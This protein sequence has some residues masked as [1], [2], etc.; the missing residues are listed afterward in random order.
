MCRVIHVY[1][2]GLVGNVLQIGARKT[3]IMTEKHFF[4]DKTGFKKKK[5]R[6]PFLQKEQE[7]LY[8]QITFKIH[9]SDVNLLQFS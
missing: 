9:L 5:Y 6:K 4:L 8:P 2:E 3:T 1:Y 7:I